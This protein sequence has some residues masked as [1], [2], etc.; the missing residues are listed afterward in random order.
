MG[1]IGGRLGRGGFV[2]LGGFDQ[3]ND[4]EVLDRE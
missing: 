3:G 2:S 4:G 1:V